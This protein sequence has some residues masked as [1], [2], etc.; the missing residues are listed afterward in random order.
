MI[1][2]V[3]AASMQSAKISGPEAPGDGFGAL[4][5]PRGLV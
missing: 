1:F 4:E 3:F 2:R 5:T